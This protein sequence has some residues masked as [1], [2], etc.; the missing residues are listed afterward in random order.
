MIDAVVG[1]G[2]IAVGLFAA[3]STIRDLLRTWRAKHAFERQLLTV[4]KEDARLR[5]TLTE[6]DAQISVEAVNR[7]VQGL[8]DDDRAMVERALSHPKASYLDD[9]VRHVARDLSPK[10]QQKAL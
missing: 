6:P 8:S 10:E 1:L 5:H 9:V 4:A 3:R 7:A 2:T